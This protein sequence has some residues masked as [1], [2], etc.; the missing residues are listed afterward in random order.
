MLRYGHRKSKDIDIFVPD[1][2]YLGYVNPRLSSVAESVTTN[3]V[4]TAGFIKL[5]L[6]KGEIDFVAAP[7]LT[8]HP[9]EDWQIAG[10]AVR[11]ETAAE[12]M[13]KKMWHRGNNATARDLFDLAMVAQEAPE[14][15][16]IALPWF[17]RHK[18]AFLAQIQTRKAVLEA[19]FGE[20]DTIGFHPSYT[21]CVASVSKILNDE[22]R[23]SAR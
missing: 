3:Y 9:F 12:I 14:Q 13:A 11:V 20:I 8:E 4:E 22:A 19:Q 1:P 6:P 16:K 5:V 10:T 15:I 18:S 23:T 21:E 2:Q 17:E 7:N